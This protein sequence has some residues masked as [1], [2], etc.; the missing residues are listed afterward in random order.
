VAVVNGSEVEW[1]STVSHGTDFDGGEG[2][3][4]ADGKVW[5]TTQVDDRVWELDVRA[6]PNRI[7]IVYDDAQNTPLTGVDSIVGTPS[8]D[9][10][11]A[12]DGGDMELALIGM[13]LYFSSQRGPGGEGDGVT[14]EVRGPFR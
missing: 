5:F 9:L 4:C 11:V 7:R 1:T 12:E 6:T 14:Y 8:G 10:F 2:A 13:R 3:W